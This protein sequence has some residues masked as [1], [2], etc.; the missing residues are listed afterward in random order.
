MGALLLVLAAPVTALEPVTIT[1]TIVLAVLLLGA[2]STGAA[3]VLNYRLIQDEG[4]TSAST[5]TYL[6]PAVALVLG[7]VVLDEP[8]TWRLLLGAAVILA[9]VAMSEERL[10]RSTAARQAD[11]KREGAAP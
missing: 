4:A 9:G 2:L 6:I 8:L 3:Y 11:R 5:V 1:P 7:A 10:I